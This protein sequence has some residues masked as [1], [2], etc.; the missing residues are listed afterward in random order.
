MTSR[1]TIKDVAERAGVSPST[2]SQVVRGGSGGNVRISEATR[3]RVKDVITELGYRPNATAR[4]LRLQRTQLIAVMVPDLTNPF[5]PQLIRGAQRTLEDHDF[6]LAV[7]DSHGRAD[8]ERAFVA[9]MLEGRVDGA[10]LVPLY[11]NDEDIAPLIEARLAVATTAAQTSLP[12]VDVIAEDLG[13]TARIAMQHLIEKGHRRIAHIA[14][15]QAT[16][17]GRGRLDAY[18]AALFANG[19]DVDESLIRYASFDEPEDSSHCEA[20]L[21]LKNPP[22]A[23]FAANDQLAITAIKTCRRH[24]AVVPRQMAVIGIDNIPEATAIDPELTTLDLNPISFG[25][26][27]AEAVLNRLSGDIEASGRR[28]AIV[29]RLVER[30]ST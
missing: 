14:G 17:P 21:V 20:V 24:G 13:A 12:S 18:R 8:R 30:N 5:F 9:S 16:E 27:L 1:V 29:G 25:S 26:A 10:I 4:N 3:G 28:E 22:T 23:I 2:V 7:Y 19:I 6:Q 15:T 11:L